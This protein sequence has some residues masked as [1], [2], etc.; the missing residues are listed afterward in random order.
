MLV[1]WC[2]DAVSLSRVLQTTV[3]FGVDVVRFGAQNVSFGVL[4]G[5]SLTP[6]GTILAPR[7]HPGGPRE[8]QDGHGG[9]G[10]LFW[11]IFKLFWDTI[12]RA[13]WLPLT[14]FPFVLRAGF[15]DTL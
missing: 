15:Q 7:V 3:I 2:P 1:R 5:S 9:S 6:W 14:R 12:L 10:A 11:T 13:V 8:Q 4:V